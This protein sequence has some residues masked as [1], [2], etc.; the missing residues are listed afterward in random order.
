MLQGAIC[1]THLYV[2]L[3]SYHCLTIGKWRIRLMHIRLT[4]DDH[5]QTAIGHSGLLNSYGPI[6]DYCTGARID[7]YL[8]QCR[9]QGNLQIFQLRQK[10]RLPL[11]LSRS[12]HT[13]N[14]TIIDLGSAGAKLLIDTV[15]YALC[16]AKITAIE[17]QMYQTIIGIGGWHL[18]L[19]NCTRR[20]SACIELIDLNARAPRLSARAS[21]QQIALCNGIHLT[22]STLKRGHQQGPPTQTF[23]IPHRGNHDINALTRAG[24]GR[25]TRRHHDGGYIT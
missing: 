6:H 7:H 19:Y 9:W 25:Q 14:P 5:R 3:M 12:L 16:D 8:S 17:L 24:K 10:G 23:C 18:L 2:S 1:R 15:R 4:T 22:I 21:D 13:D 20:N 11:G